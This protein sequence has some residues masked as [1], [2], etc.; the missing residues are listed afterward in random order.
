M[1]RGEARRDGRLWFV[2][3]SGGEAAGSG[4]ARLSYEKHWWG[5]R[6]QPFANKLRSQHRLRCQP[7]KSIRSGY[8]RNTDNSTPLK[9]FPSNFSRSGSFPGLL[10][11]SRLVERASI[12]RV[13][14]QRR[15]QFRSRE[16]NENVRSLSDVR[17]NAY[18]AP[19]TSANTVLECAE[20]FVDYHDRK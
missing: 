8:I 1:R 16:R 9:R 15:L 3:V 2:I 10:V 17:V 6:G 18:T 4:D 20:T 7:Q 11:C 13:N 14:E 19:F 12:S 5:H